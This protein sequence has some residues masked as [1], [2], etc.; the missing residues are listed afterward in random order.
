MTPKAK[1]GVFLLALVAV[2]LA[3]EAVA[4]AYPPMQ[5]GTISEVI[6]WATARTPLVPFLAGVLCGHLFF[7]RKWR[8]Q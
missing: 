6:W 5:G 1:T 3:W 4:L 7:P 8:N 2:A